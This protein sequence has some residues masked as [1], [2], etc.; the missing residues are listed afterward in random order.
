M[1]NFYHVL[2]GV[3]PVSRC[4]EII[5]RGISIHS[6][7]ASIGFND[8]RVDNS[9]RIGTLHWFNPRADKD[10]GDMMVGF[11]LEANRESFGFDLFPFA[12]DLQI[13]RAHV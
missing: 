10:I 8:D 9:Y 11:A 6:H 4:N 2:P 7:E 1:K 3:V 13:G 5:R 12:H